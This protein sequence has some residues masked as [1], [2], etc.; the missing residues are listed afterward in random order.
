MHPHPRTC[1]IDH[2]I[3]LR[4]LDL[5]VR[6]FFLPFTDVLDKFNFHDCIAYLFDFTACLADFGCGLLL[7]FL[8]MYVFF[9]WTDPMMGLSIRL[10]RYLLQDGWYQTGHKI[11]SGNDNSTKAHLVNPVIAGIALLPIGCFNEM[12]KAPEQAPFRCQFIPDCSGLSD[13]SWRGNGHWNRYEGF[14]LF[15]S[16]EYLIGKMPEWFLM[17][18]LMVLP[19]YRCDNASQL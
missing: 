13:H 3:K 4:M 1:L 5:D 18:S 7:L 8:W 16:F 15:D 19:N 6:H 2:L 17:L 9:S 11:E 12:L 14:H 10:C